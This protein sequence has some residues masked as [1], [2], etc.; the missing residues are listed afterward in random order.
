MIEI[1]NTEYDSQAVILF[2]EAINDFV[3]LFIP[4]CC[5]EI[6]FFICCHPLE[7]GDPVS[8]ITGFSFSLE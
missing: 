3:N 5:R 1:N 7:R 4:H 2:F 6:N 8:T